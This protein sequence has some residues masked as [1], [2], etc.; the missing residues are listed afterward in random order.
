MKFNTLVI[1]DEPLARQRVLNLLKDVPEVIVVGECSTGKKAISAISELKPE[2]IFLDIKLKDMTGFDVLS[3]INQTEMP[4]VI[5]ITA[6]DQFALKAFD[7]FALDYLQ[8][9]FKDERF[10]KSI[11]K[12][13]E[14]LKQKSSFGF[15]DNI[16]NLLNHIKN[17]DI[18]N[19]I[20]SKKLPIK[21]GNKVVFI[22]DSEIKYIIASGYY[23]E[24]HTEAKKHLLRD[25]LSNLIDELDYRNFIRI[26][27]STIININ[28]IQELISSNY[29]EFDVKMKDNKLFRVSK[30]YKKDFLTR[31]G[32]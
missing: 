21:L 17:S 8:K 11:S 4:L 9:P 22:D 20:G 19:N 18:K 5:F 31:I 32:L 26:H 14:Y 24:I 3:Q 1:D 29:G 10:Y 16:Q 7:F 25:S 23:A 2:L 28:F 12:A 30:S 6:Y 13:L 27:R 15:E